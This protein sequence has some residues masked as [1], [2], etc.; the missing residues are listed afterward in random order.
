MSSSSDALPSAI[1]VP[2]RGRAPGLR[3]VGAADLARALQ[4]ADDIL[5][6]SSALT[7]AHRAAIL[8][9]A[10]RRP[11]L[12][13][14]DHAALLQTSLALTSYHATQLELQGLLRCQAD[15]RARRLHPGGAHVVR[16]VA[17]L[18]EAGRTLGA[19]PSPTEWPVA[20]AGSSAAQP[21]PDR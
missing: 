1:A 5:R 12:R 14:T 21:A 16:A 6:T 10:I 17:A 7:N 15:G 19:D 3:D 20:D 4:E 2:R 11:G 9:L 18:A 8:C 13:V